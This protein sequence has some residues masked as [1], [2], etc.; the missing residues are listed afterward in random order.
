MVLQPGF[1]ERK[2]ED[3]EKKLTKK[4]NQGKNKQG[5]KQQK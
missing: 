4:P 3:E 5:N 1:Q 2:K